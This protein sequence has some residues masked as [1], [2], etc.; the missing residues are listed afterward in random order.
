MFKDAKEFGIKLC[1]RKIMNKDEIVEFFFGSNCDFKRCYLCTYI[2]TS[3]PSF[4]L[5]SSSPPSS[6]PSF[7]PSSTATSIPTSISSS[8]PSF[9]SIT[10]T[11]IIKNYYLIGRQAMKRTITYS[12]NLHA[13]NSKLQTD[14]MLKMK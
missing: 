2:P 4:L 1:N 8:E 6:P 13:F 11:N 3:S 7:P 14:A 12:G 5:L 10:S 9:S